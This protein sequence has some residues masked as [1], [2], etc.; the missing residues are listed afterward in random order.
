MKPAFKLP[1][2]RAAID[3]SQ[4]A[5]QAERAADGAAKFLLR[6][7]FWPEHGQNGRKAAVSAKA[8]I[9]S[10][11]EGEHLT[12]TI[13]NMR[14]RLHRQ[15]E[16]WSKPRQARRGGK[17]DGHIES[18]N[19]HAAGNIRDELDLPGG[20]IR[21]TL[22]K[23]RRQR[24]RWSASRPAELDTA[25]AGR[26]KSSAPP[27]DLP[28]ERPRQ[29]GAIIV[30]PRVRKL[31]ARPRNHIRT[32]IWVIALLVAGAVATGIYESERLVSAVGKAHLFTSSLLSGV[33]VGN[34]ESR[35]RPDIA[36]PRAAVQPS[37]ANGRII[38]SHSVPDSYGL[39]VVSDGQLK[40]LESMRMRVPDTRIALGGLIP[41]P[42]P[43][44]LPGGKLSFI[45]YQR[46]LK[47]NAPDNASVRVIA[48]V[49]RALKFSVTGKPTTTPVEDTWA[50]RS[51]SID[52]TV[53]PMPESQEM[54]LLRP[55]D[56][57]FVLSPGRYMLVYKNQAYDFAVDGTITD[58]AQCL[59]RTDSQDGAVYSECRDLP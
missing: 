29:Q 49:K 30:D 8:R 25:G 44:T 28:L 17:Q 5:A 31:E 52:L 11:D 19:S 15:R 58:T 20:A 42:S 35:Q 21:D 27:R 6:R 18:A 24:E 22:Q 48:K 9:E 16:L 45:V 40:R 1:R 51:V 38:P 10:P 3:A 37:A 46:D 7:K 32:G 55:S 26:I 34:S 59:E 13:R 14:Q 47:T 53:A 57:D 50:V 41:K 43:V 23:I 33:G 39:F 36:S 4:G 12:R 56:P 2:A 54:V